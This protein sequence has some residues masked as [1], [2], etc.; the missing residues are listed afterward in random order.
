MAGAVGSLERVHQRRAP[1][2]RLVLRLAAE[3][4]R[5]ASRRPPAAARLR[6]VEALAAHVFHQLPVKPSSPMG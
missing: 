3:L 4:D 1:G 5:A 6:A 2:R